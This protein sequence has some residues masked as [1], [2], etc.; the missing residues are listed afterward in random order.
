LCRDPS[1]ILSFF[2]LAEKFFPNKRASVQNQTKK[3]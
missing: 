3:I 2:F 1:F